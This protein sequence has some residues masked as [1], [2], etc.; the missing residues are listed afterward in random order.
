VQAVQAKRDFDEKA[1]GDKL[2]QYYETTYFYWYNRLRKLKRPRNS[3]V[4][5]ISAVSEA[6]KAFRKEAI[7]CKGMVK[8]DK[9]KVADFTSWLEKQKQE[10]DRLMK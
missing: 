4:D 1:K 8:R 2:A 10:V 6:F 7:K 3:D 9:M 5:K